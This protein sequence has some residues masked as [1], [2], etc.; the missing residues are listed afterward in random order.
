MDSNELSF[1]AHQQL[2]K[3]IYILVNENSAFVWSININVVF[4]YL[5]LDFSVLLLT[6][7][8]KRFYLLSNLFSFT[9]LSCILF[10]FLCAVFTP[11]F[12][13]QPTLDE[14]CSGRMV[15]P[16]YI[17]AACDV[18]LTR[19]ISPG[20]TD[21]TNTGTTTSG[22][23]SRVSSSD[24]K[25]CNKMR[26]DFNCSLC[27]INLFHF[28]FDRPK[29]WFWMYLL[30]HGQLNRPLFKGWQ[31]H[32]FSPYAI[33]YC[34]LEFKLRYLRNLKLFSIRVKE[35]SEPIVLWRKGDGF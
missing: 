30:L 28:H 7:T 18:H 11:S 2:I 27:I 8:G 23:T 17:R 5:S 6:M 12:Q 19:D 4:I 10:V 15:L 31:M 26:S 32:A 14:I 22:T 3:C 9:H 25:F 29:L 16:P 35:L 24:R 20:N 33:V 1:I 21:T 13:Q 34:C